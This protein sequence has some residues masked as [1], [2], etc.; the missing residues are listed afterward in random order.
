MIDAH[1]LE[2]FENCTL[3]FEQWNHRAHV[4]AAYLYASRH[5]LEPALV[6]MRSSIKAYNAAHNVP[7]ALDRGYHETI[8]QGFMRLVHATICRHGPYQSSEEFCERHPEL[9]NKHVLLG[10]YS[11]ERIMSPAAKATFVAPDLAELP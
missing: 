3:P 9:L 10:F 1:F 8:T 6:R 11:R 7:D 2:A 5:D 4:K